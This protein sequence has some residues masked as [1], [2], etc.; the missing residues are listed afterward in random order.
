MTQPITTFTG[1]AIYLDTMIPYAL[2]RNIDSDRVKKLFN[3]LQ[4]GE[5]EAF[6]SALTFDVTVHSP[7]DLTGFYQSNI[8]PT[9]PKKPVRSWEGE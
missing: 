4:V 2:L 6:T 9:G 1:Q 5:L 7:G 8:Y 3:R